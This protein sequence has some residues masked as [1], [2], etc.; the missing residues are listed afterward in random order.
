[1]APSTSLPSK[2]EL[3]RQQVA[4]RRSR[5]AAEVIDAPPPEAALARSQLSSI[6]RSLSQAFSRELLD[7]GLMT[8][9]PEGQ[10]RVAS[11]DPSLLAPNPQRGRLTDRGLQELAASL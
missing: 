7:Q 6:A 8:F 10:P 1:M 5:V 11:Y 3:R 2:A 4:E 9:D